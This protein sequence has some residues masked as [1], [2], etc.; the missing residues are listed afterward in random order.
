MLG[1]IAA[2][3]EAG[4]HR[5]EGPDPKARL[6][7]AHRSPRV[8]FRAARYRHPP[9][10]GFPARVTSRAFRPRSRR[11]H[12]PSRHALH[13]PVGRPAARDLG[14]K[15]AA[16]G[17]DGIELACWGDHFE[18]AA[19]A[20]RRRLLPRAARPARP[21]RPACHAISEPPRRPG[22]LRR[23]RRAAQG[24]PAAARLGRRRA[25]G[26]PPAR[27]R[28]DEATPPAAASASSASTSSTASPARAS[29][30]CSTRS[31]PVPGTMID[32]GYER[33]AERWNPILD[34]FAPRASGSRWKCIPPRSR[35]TST[36]PQR[37]LDAI[38][39]RDGVRLQLRP[40]PPGLAGRRLR[41]VHPR[42]PR[43]HL[44]RPRQGRDRHAQRPQRHPRQPPRLRRRR[45]RLGLPLARAAAASTSRRSSA[46]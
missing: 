38:D 25:R 40:Q 6:Q 44:P 45:P 4:D 15:A 39:G 16:F 22:G 23:D 30:T 3:H 11:L 18:V 9:T 27:R 19:R 42:V 43:P 10:P 5:A 24:D 32:A 12:G 13:R 35:S 7:L 21:P 20:R 46:R 34:V 31:R 41:R 36:P 33:F 26:R 28:G 1:L 14:R 37:A 29:G 2:G 8:G 17:Y